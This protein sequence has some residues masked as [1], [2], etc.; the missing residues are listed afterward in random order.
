MIPRVL[1]NWRRTIRLRL[2]W[3]VIACVLPVWLAAGYIVF[4]AYQDKKQTIEGRT[5][6]T[7]RALS[8]VVDREL[9]SIESALSALATSPSLGSGDFAAFH[10]QARELLKTYEGADIILADATGQQLVNSYLPM[11]SPLPKRAVSDAVRRVFEQGR[12]S[13][14]GLFKGAVT[15][16]FLVGVD[17]PVFQDGKVVYDLAM[18]LPAERFAAILSQQQLPPQWVGLILDRD[19][20]VVGRTLFPERYVGVRIPPLLLPQPGAWERTAEFINLDNIPA[21]ASISRSRMSEWA[22][23]INVPKTAIF[24]E[25]RGWLLW[26]IVGTSLLSAVGVVL[27]VFI[28]RSIARSIRALIPQAMDL[29]SGK[30]VAPG[31]L[32]F[33]E[34]EAVSKALGTASLLLMERAEELKRS[35]RDLEEF[36]AVASHDLQEPLRKISAFGERLRANHAHALDPEGLDFLGRM[37]SAAQR[38]QVLILDLL[39]YSRVST[40]PNPFAT[41]DLGVIAKEAKADLE[42]EIAEAG[43]TI[44][45]ENLPAA[46]VDLSQMRRVFQNLLSNALKYHGEA[47]PRITV[48]GEVI[49]AESGERARISVQDNGIG[50]D[51]QYV[52]RIF[53]PFQR[54]HGKHTFS[55]TGIGL[56]IVRKSVERHGGTVTAKSKPGEG[57]TFILDIPLKQP[58]AER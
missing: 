7:A 24:A 21:I 41:A 8:S 20:V 46:E 6:E 50:F 34:T 23:V 42:R 28:G 1:N 9:A 29:A 32:G 18:T 15:G 53:Q 51:E 35:N 39:E 10:S 44:E 48:K 4:I 37:E 47:A 26:A 52:E 38:M 13:V 45:I 56:A 16:R 58:K 30:L 2:A 12:A 17:V 36:A 25:L 57:S 11:D 33:A 27:A 31:A 14:A 49:S 5:L 55:G 54:L 43:G 22:V 40:R 3:L 19:R